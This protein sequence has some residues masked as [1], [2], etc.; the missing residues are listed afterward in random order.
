MDFLNTWEL[1]ILH[2][3]QEN[4]TCPFL[5]TIMPYVS[6]FCDGGSGWIFVALV[7]LCFPKTRKIGITIGVALLIGLLGCNAI[8]K[9]LVDR[10]RPFVWDPHVSL[11]LPPPTDASFPSGHSTAAFEGAV[12][13]FLYH[14][15][16]GIPALCLAASVAF[17]RLYLYM[18]YPTDVL[19]GSILGT[20]SGIAAYAMVNWLYKRNV[21]R[22]V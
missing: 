12:V 14:K 8:L 11:L 16:W 1:G 2:W 19:C 15:K 20:L 4:L 10:T 9:P 17:S 6:R 3:I 5:D 13:L 22:M 7:L 18:H 21:H